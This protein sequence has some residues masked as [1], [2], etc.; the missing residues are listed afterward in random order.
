MMYF[1]YSSMDN[2]SY[3]TITEASAVSQPGSSGP[4]MMTRFI[5]EVAVGLP[6]ALIGIIGNVLAF[7]VLWR[8]HQRLTTNVV[9]QWL[10]IF[11]TLVLL[12][13]ILLRSLRYLHIQVGGL[14]GYIDVYKHIFVC[15]YP[16]VFFF[17]FVDTWLTVVLTI[18][19]YI[20]VC[21]PLQA[22]QICTLPRTYKRI[23]ALVIISI[24]FSLPR[25]FEYK[26]ADNPHGF[27]LA[28]LMK[29]EYYIYIYRIGLFFIFMYFI[30]MGLLVVLNVLLL[31]ALWVA[32]YHRANMQQTRASQMNRSIT[33]TVVTVVLMCALCNG[34][35]MIAHLLWSLEECYSNLPHLETPRR[36]LAL[37]SNLL[38]T[39]NSATN[40]F[41]YCMCS[42][43]FRLVLLR[44]FPCYRANQQRRSSS[45]SR[46]TGTTYLSLKH[47]SKKRR[48]SDT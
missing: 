17:R 21:F 11:D 36:Y 45:S 24:F 15:L 8:Q 20:A 32:G 19:R 26:Y 7:V 23:I 38:V 42:R 6:I 44:T 2:T 31:R 48:G 46:T 43:K 30:P 35:A 9:L 1:N 34:S 22:Q 13:T 10:A 18:D 25:F 47:S 39:V 12:S 33:I 40:F 29:N 3:L 4:T 28:K 5:F 27:A 16:C 37:V 14:D 41:I